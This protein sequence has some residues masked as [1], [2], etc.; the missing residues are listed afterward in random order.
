MEN[1][2][3]QRINSMGI[4][5]SLLLLLFMHF[6]HSYQLLWVVVVLLSLCQFLPYL[7]RLIFAP[8]IVLSEIIG[9]FAFKIF[10]S[11][12]FFGIITPIG[13][14]R[15]KTGTDPLQLKKWKNNN[16]SV[17]MIRDL[18]IKESDFENPY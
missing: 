12:C 8:V 4:G 15:R 11:I 5:I 2:S 7:L 3:E 17:F 9:L 16:S 6:K 13:F 18:T 10:L 1:I 14:L